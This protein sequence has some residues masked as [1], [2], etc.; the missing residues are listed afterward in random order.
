[1]LKY[2]GNESTFGFFEQQSVKS[3]IQ[4]PGDVVICDQ[5]TFPA[6]MALVIRLCC[7]ANAKVLY[8]ISAAPE[9]FN[10]KKVV[11]ANLRQ[12]I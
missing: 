5:L 12:V 6:N 4:S 7:N 9:V 3:H 8:F 10:M 11:S 1:M 2:A